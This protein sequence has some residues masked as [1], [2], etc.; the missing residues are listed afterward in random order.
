MKAWRLARLAAA[1]L[2]CARLAGAP[3]LAGMAPRAW[4]DLWR[5]PDQQGQALLEAGK[6]ALAADVFTDPRRRAYADLEAG[7]Y[8]AAARLLAP[9][10]D[11]TSEYNRGNALARSGQLLAALADYDAALKQSPRDR[12]I[13]HNR[14]LVERQLRKQHSAGAPHGGRQGGAGQQGSSSAQQPSGRSGQSGAGRSSAGEDRRK[15][16]GRRGAS[17]AGANAGQS[18]SANAGAGHSGADASRGAGQAGSAQG[19]RPASPNTPTMGSGARRDSANQARRDAEFAA[20][21]ERNRPAPGQHGAGAAQASARRA[22]VPNAQREAGER[23]PRRKP[24]SEK[25][26]ALEQWL[27]QIPDSPAGL[28]R[29]KF[30][31]Q[32]MLKHPDASREE[33]Q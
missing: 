14:D 27:R 7:R 29:R 26:L 12:D 4:T 24:V 28:L 15:S 22:P 6:P 17:G 20:G 3:A 31:I 13:R 5:T 11:P 30:M 19:S 8:G 23:S 33:P 10:K 25:T 32:Y 18:A 1:A 21:L 16:K 9:F 2:C